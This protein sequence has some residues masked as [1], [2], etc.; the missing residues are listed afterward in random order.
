MN[1]LM[2]QAV[3]VQHL[4]IFIKISYKRRDPETEF[5]MTTPAVA[6]RSLPILLLPDRKHRELLIRLISSQQSIV[7]DD[8]FDE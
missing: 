3:V 4:R 5:R 7:H 1:G 2:L 6:F 8:E